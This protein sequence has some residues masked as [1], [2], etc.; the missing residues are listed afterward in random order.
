M[1]I[2]EKKQDDPAS[3]DISRRDAITDPD[4]CAD[5][6]VNNL[7]CGLLKKADANVCKDDCIGRL[8]CPVTCGTC[9][10]YSYKNHICSI[11]KCQKCFLTVTQTPAELSNFNRY[12][13]CIKCQ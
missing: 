1:T 2:D 12:V 5:F 11:I 3:V 8:I 4:I 10:E 6:D 9:G 13:I 7:A